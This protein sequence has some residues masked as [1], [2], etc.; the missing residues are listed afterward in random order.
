[1]KSLVPIKAC[2][3]TGTAG[4]LP[5]EAAQIETLLQYYKAA[6]ATRGIQWV[7]TETLFKYPGTCHLHQKKDTR[8]TLSIRRTTTMF[9]I[10]SQPTV[11]I[12]LLRTHFLNC[13]HHQ[14][15]ECPRPAQCIQTMSH[16]RYTVTTPSP[17]ETLTLHRLLLTSMPHTAL[18]HRLARLLCD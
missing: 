9:L 12:L 13:R 2:R 17:P 16:H 8:K 7:S 6:M 18:P 10:S 14:A 4:M 1:M 11:I 3:W 5:T 15:R